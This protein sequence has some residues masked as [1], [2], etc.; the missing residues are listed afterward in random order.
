MQ[1][2]AISTRDMERRDW[3][4]A[5]QKGIGGSDVAAILGLNPWKTPLDV[6]LEKVEQKPTERPENAKMKAG[7]MLEDTIAN[8][9]IDETGHKVVRDNKIRI[10]P[11]FKHL[12]ANIDRII[13]SSND[14]GTGVLEVKASSG[15]LV[16]SFEKDE[17]PVPPYWYCQLQHYLN[18]TGYSW[19]AI[20]YLVDGWD[21]HFQYFEADQELIRDMTGKLNEFWEGHV[22]SGIPPEPIN[23]KDVMMLYPGARE[24]S[25]LEAKDEVY[26]M[27]LELKRV[28]ESLKTYKEMRDKI[29]EQIKMVLRDNERLTYGGETLVTWKASTSNRVDSKKLQKLYP[30]VYRE[31]TNE[32][33]SRR[34]LIK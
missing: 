19:G 26:D 13:L 2:T 23:E 29:A 14:K 22:L 21:F 31:V 15:Q 3:L 27:W 20:A 34:F 24:D 18:V 6:Y 17:W 30:D 33:I 4:K 10:H 9:F 12:L 28:D 7:K 25:Q 8:Y 16:R 1:K 5:R 11:N 32:S